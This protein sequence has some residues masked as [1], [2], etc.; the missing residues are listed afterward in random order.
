MILWKRREVG[1]VLVGVVA[2]GILSYFFRSRKNIAPGSCLLLQE[3]YCKQAVWIDSPWTTGDRL[4]AFSLPAGTP[5]FSPVS[6]KVSDIVT[7]TIDG[8]TYPG[9]RITTRDSNK[10]LINEES[11]NIISYS[12]DGSK[13]SGVISKGDILF[14]ATKNRLEKIGSYNLVFSISE[15]GIVE[16]KMV[17]R[18]NYERIKELFEDI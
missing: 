18:V 13:G 8:V 4:L 1:I 17:S 16:G 10:Y 9:F 15:S 2:L 6:G 14:R 11:H 5:V 3:K 7:Y 12:S